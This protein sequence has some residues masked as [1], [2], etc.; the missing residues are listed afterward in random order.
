V[1]GTINSTAW[2]SVKASEIIK[3]IQ[4]GRVQTY[5]IFFLGGALVLAAILILNFA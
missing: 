1:N 4:S 2:I 3:P 5:A